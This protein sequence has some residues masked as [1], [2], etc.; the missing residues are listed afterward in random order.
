[1]P[2]LVKIEGMLWMRGA[3]GVVL[4][5]NGKVAAIVTLA[6]DRDREEVAEF[7]R[8]VIRERAGDVLIE[9]FEVER[10]ELNAALVTRRTV[11][12]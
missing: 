2:E 6:D 4:V 5:Q 7:V 9:A 3:A 11:A 1:M 12:T 8:L 10:A